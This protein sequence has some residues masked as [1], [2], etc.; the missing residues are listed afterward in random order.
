[1]QQEVEHFGEGLGKST[2]TK[3]KTKAIQLHENK[4]G[5]TTNHRTARFK[6][7]IEVTMKGNLNNN[8]EIKLT[9]PIHMLTWICNTQ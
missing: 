4:V 6:V 5:P 1:M 8:F 9:P 3:N 7:A 2:V